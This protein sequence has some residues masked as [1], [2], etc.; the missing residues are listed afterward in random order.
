MF[1]PLSVG[2]K[3]VSKTHE[4]DVDRIGIPKAAGRDHTVP[5]ILQGRDKGKP[6]S[7]NMSS[8]DCKT[9]ILDIQL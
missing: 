5:I 4:T 3:R 1:C 8:I 9:Q 7:M 2:G 6:R